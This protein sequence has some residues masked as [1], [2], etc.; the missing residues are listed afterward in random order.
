MSIP[1]IT[2]LVSKNPPR[3][4]ADIRTGDIIQF[5]KPLRGSGR[6]EGVVR[7]DGDM[8]DSC[9][10]PVFVAYGEDGT[11]Y[12]PLQSGCVRVDPPVTGTKED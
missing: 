4:G 3:P 9:M 7:Y 2:G 5:D 6:T 8:R 1:R 11:P 10:R 12:Y